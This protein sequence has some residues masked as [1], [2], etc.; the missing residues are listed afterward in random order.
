M[1]AEAGS[2]DRDPDMEFYPRL[3]AAPNAATTTWRDIL[4]TGRSFAPR[5]G[6]G[7]HS[8]PKK[9]REMALS[10]SGV[11]GGVYFAGRRLPGREAGREARAQVAGRRGLLRPGEE[12]PAAERGGD[13]R[14]GAGLRAGRAAHV[15]HARSGVVRHEAQDGL[16]RFPLLLLQLVRVGTQPRPQPQVEV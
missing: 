8:D 6:E 12:V 2:G 15:L 9:A 5:A 10:N 3:K 14:V 7:A 1:P 13:A 4:R 11:F 16:L